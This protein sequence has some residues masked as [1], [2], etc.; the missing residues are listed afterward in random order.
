MKVKFFNIDYEFESSPNYQEQYI[1]E[2][3]VCAWG[4]DHAKIHNDEIEYLNTIREIIIDY[5][6]D[7][8]DPLDIDF[9]SNLISDLTNETGEYILDFDYEILAD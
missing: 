9:T 1:I 8:F 4:T 2:N 5:D 6:D 3:S 7:S